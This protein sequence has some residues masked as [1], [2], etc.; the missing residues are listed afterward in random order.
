MKIGVA[1]TTFAR[2][3]MGAIAI[4]EIKKHASVKIKRYVVPGV[5]DLPVAAKKLIEEHGCDIVLSLGMP[6]AQV[7][8]KTCAHEA[9]QGHIIAQLMTNT[10]I[11]EVFVYEDEAEDEKQLVWLAEQRTREHA[12]NAVK[13]LLY[14]K[15]LEAEAGTGQRQGFE[16]VGAVKL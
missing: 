13:L 9:S 11:I 7:I 15:K 1:D 14:P 12:Q 10:H 4:D 8:D 5:K 16:D 3:D 6:G 2:V